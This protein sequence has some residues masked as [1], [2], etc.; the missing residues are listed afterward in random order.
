VDSL[1][2]RVGVGQRSGAAYA[3]LTPLRRDRET[4]L[5]RRQPKFHPA[6][7]YRRSPQWAAVALA[8]VL[9][10]NSIG[11]CPCGPAP[12]TKGDPHACCPHTAEDKS[13][14]ETAASVSASSAPCC[15]PQMTPSAMTARIDDRE[16]LLDTLSL[17]GTSYSFPADSVVSSTAG[18][19]AS[20]HS[21]SAP[22]RTTVL[23]I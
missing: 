16:T 6:P 18:A 11:L 19:L 12:A 17:V 2:N 13:V 15:S 21:F 1:S 20:P 8:F 23:R 9:C 4:A 5:S 10:L 3:R 14:P 22:P 7:G